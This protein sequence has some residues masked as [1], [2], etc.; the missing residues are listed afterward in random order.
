MLYYSKILAILA[1]LFRTSPHYAWIWCCTSA[2]LHPISWHTTTLLKSCG[3][4]FLTPQLLKIVVVCQVIGWRLALV[5]HRKLKL[6][7]YRLCR[8][9]Y[10]PIFLETKYRRYGYRCRYFYCFALW[11]TH[12]L[13]CWKCA[14][15]FSLLTLETRRHSRCD[16]LNLING[17]FCN[18]HV[19]YYEVSNVILSN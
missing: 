6:G 17:H 9:R 2:T 16:T 3:V 5:R 14:Q 10:L 11:P 19:T 13:R 18:F 7:R 4:D 8:Y 1:Y 15:R 12:A